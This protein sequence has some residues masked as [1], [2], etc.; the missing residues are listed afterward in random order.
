MRALGLGGLAL[1]AACGPPEV[2]SQ[3]LKDGSWSFTCELPMDECVRR[4]Q[5]KCN[6]QRYRITEGT[7]ETRLRDV[8][9]FERADH[10]SHLNFVC[11]DDGQ[12][13]LVTLGGDDKP[14]NA[15]SGAAKPAPATIRVCTKGETRA[16]VGAAACK[17]GQACLPDGSGFAACDCGPVTPVAPT[18]PVTPT[19]DSE[20]TITP[21]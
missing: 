16:C 8:P 12:N 18:T 7:S 20:P 9:P 4:A 3:R 11:T 17:G 10:T 15:K 5:E 1:L 14:A 19:V 21:P 13:P 6:L 2:Q